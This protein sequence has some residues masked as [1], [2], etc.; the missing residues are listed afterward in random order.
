MMYPLRFLVLLLLLV[1]AAQVPALAASASDLSGDFVTTRNAPT[2]RRLGDKLHDVPSVL[3]YG[4]ICDTVVLRWRR[5]SIATG[6]TQL[7]VPDAYFQ[8]GDAGKLIVVA[9]AGPGGDNLAGK[10]AQVDSKS[11]VIL[12]LPAQTAVE[13]HDGYVAYGTDTAPALNAIF[14]G[15]S[16]PQWDLGELRLPRGVCGV[17]STIVLPGGSDKGAFGLE[18]M[19][20]RGGGRGVSW[21]VAL[22]SMRAVIQEPAGEHNQANL[23]DFGID[24]SGL[25]DF[26]ADVQGGRS[27]R[28]SGLYY[29]DNRIAGLHL[30]VVA[31]N[32]DGTLTNPN[33]WYTNIWEFMV[34]HS[35][36]TADTTSVMRH[37][38]PLFGILSS[39]GDSHF[40]D[41]VIAHAS[42]ANV[43]D[44]GSAHNFYTN[45]HAWGHPRYEFWVRGKTQFANCEVDGATEAGVRSDEDGLVWTG[46]AMIS[47][48][49]GTPVGFFFPAASGHHAIVGPAIQDIAPRA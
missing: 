28:H 26:G 34:D 30:G 8:P 35:T 33:G 49:N 16:L 19:T 40:S 21:L 46:G 24:G 22:A 44:T 39:A 15:T 37:D 17:G 13:V 20:L 32:P 45:V 29:N 47:L 4:A 36:I 27:G 12:S 31:V 2:A 42:V 1:S 3:D 7:T 10:I 14:A 5:V 38:A 41:L 6:S 25:A 23:L 18:Q 11:Q 9:G 43:R 48:N